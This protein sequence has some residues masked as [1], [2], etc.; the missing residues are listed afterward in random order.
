MKKRAKSQTKVKEI[1]GPRGGD[2]SFIL[3]PPK[4]RRG[5]SDKQ[6]RLFVRL[7]RRGFLNDKICKDM[8]VSA[9][10]VSQLRA[11]VKRAAL[12]KYTLKDYLKAGRPLRYG[13]KV[14]A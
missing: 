4:Q 8:K 10:T 14:L 3:E 13:N 2:L 11:E 5:L 7:A 1:R 9:F 12:K 6:V